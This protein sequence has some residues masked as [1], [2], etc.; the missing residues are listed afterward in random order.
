MSI[1]LASPTKLFVWIL[2]CGFIPTTIPYASTSNLFF[3]H[4]FPYY[5]LGLGTTYASS[6]LFSL[7]LFPRI[8]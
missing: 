3:F 5:F 7:L 2:R 6:N 1:D 4:S 8:G